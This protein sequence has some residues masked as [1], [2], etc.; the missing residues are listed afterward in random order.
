MP[1]LR[2]EARNSTASATSSGD[3]IRRED[4]LPG[5]LGEHLL[6]GH[7]P[8]RRVAREQRVEVGTGHVAGHHDVD[9]DVVPPDLP[10]QG[11]RGAHHRQL[12]RRVR[13]QLGGVVR[14]DR[15][16]IC[17]IAPPPAARRWGSAARLTSMV[18]NRLT[19]RARSQ[20]ERSTSSTRASS[21]LSAATLTTASSRPNAS[22]VLATSAL[23]AIGVG[24]VRRH[25][26]GA[27][28]EHP[29]LVG[30]PLELLRSTGTERD[31]GPVT[32]QRERARPA[33]PLAGA[34]HDRDAPGEGAVGHWVAMAMP[35]SAS[36][37]EKGTPST[38]ITTS[39][40]IVPLKG[41][42]AS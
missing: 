38:S 5:R 41:N 19:A 33:D 42:G 3:G 4:A 35:I 9:A 34:G 29:H 39:P 32:G 20:S 37:S 11:L 10:S 12:G 26:Q 21:T 23:A 30:D 25:A 6:D 18:P 36:G 2:A 31:V 22:T 14:V 16:P 24:D 13:R 7:P 1:A 28:P 27:P 8:P 17:T 15:V 40:T